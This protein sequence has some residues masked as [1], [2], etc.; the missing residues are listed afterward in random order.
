MTTGTKAEENFQKINPSHTHLHP[1]STLHYKRLL[2]EYGK[3]SHSN[4]QSSLAD[5]DAK[6]LEE[7]LATFQPALLGSLSKLNSLGLRDDVDEDVS[8]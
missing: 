1:H 7:Y 6:T 8:N 4:G 3:S 2:D 5:M